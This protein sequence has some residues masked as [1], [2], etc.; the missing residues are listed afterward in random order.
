[1][2][3]KTVDDWIEEIDC[4]LEYRKTFGREAA[5]KQLEKDYMNDPSGHTA[6]GPNLIYSMGDSLMS[7][8]TVPD[9]EFVVT[10]ER[11]S[12][13]D[14]A[15]IVESLDNYFIRK[16]RFKRYMDR[17]ILHGYLYGVIILKVGYDSEFGWS[18]Y[19]DI[20][21]QQMMGMTFTQFDKKGRRIESPDIQPGWPW[22]R[23]VLP[24]DFVVPWGTVFI[25]DAPWVA[26]RIVRHIDSIKADPKYVNT[27]RLQPS[28]TM[29]D[30]MESY[31]HVG[32][33]K[34]K[35]H[36]RGISKT[37]KK[38]EFVEMWEI[39]DRLKGEILVVCR[40]HGKFLRKRSD[41]IQLACG[42]P[43]VTCTLNP[44]PRAFWTTPPAYYLGQIQATQF[45][46]SKQAEKQ[47]R[48]SVLKFL[49]RKNALTKEAFS[50]LMS[51]DVGAAEPVD[52]ITP[53]NEIIA[54]VN[55]GF[56]WD[57]VT[58]SENSRRDAREAIGFSRNQL[59]EFDAS[60]RRT[61]RE[62]T[63]VAF[64][65][66]RRMSRRD[67]AIAD[68][69]IGV[70][71]KVNGIVFEYWKV[72]RQVMHDEGWPTITGDSLKGD[73]LYSVSLST[74]RQISRAE[75]KVEAL[76]MLG[77]LAPFLQG[78]DI[79]ALYQYLTDAVSDPAF[80]R[81][82]A[83]MTGRQSAAPAA[84]PG[85]PAAQPKQGTMAGGQR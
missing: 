42:L 80:E 78:A 62:T 71:S 70:I 84:L 76:M 75:R 24:H 45:D 30:F 77:Q 33:E 20:G 27:S 40:D 53:M 73:Y 82:L 64:G 74:K 56:T 5:W 37:P 15:P 19:Y 51:S 43:F 60:S 50:R 36:I 18:P 38:P 48:I 61:A 10:P 35:A 39:R 8:L 72:P 26:H 1:M 69:Y 25:E 83:P 16:L 22:I 66:Q 14:K 81:I 79:R 44:H 28:I 11:R 2:A 63:Q 65:A 4:A 34:Q 68:T 67:Q 3:N 9:P 21:E 41:A 47:R 12:G 32:S 54:Q 58:H 46:I 49:Y 31:L 55:T 6:I 52:G 29:A 57:H 59:G 23:P 17:A 7:A 85:G 13:L